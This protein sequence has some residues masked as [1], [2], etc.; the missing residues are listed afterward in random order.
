[1]EM[2]FY[3]ES[4][5]FGNPKDREGVIKMYLDLRQKVVALLAYECG[6]VLLLVLIM[7]VCCLYVSFCA[8]DIIVGVRFSGV[9]Y[10]FMHTCTCLQK[11]FT[12]TF[13]YR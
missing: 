4:T 3:D 12:F 13:L 6:C 5:R 7:S 8:R 2:L 10:F 9:C 11:C 1:M